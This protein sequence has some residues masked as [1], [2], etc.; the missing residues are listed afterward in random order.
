MVFDGWFQNSRHLGRGQSEREYLM[1][2]TVMLFAKELRHFGMILE[3]E[4]SPGLLMTAHLFR[5]YGVSV[6]EDFEVC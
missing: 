4:G 6:H 1:S 5:S 3:R 2:M